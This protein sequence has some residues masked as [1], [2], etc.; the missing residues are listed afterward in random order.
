MLL[1]VII[2]HSKPQRP[3]LDPS[4]ASMGAST[5]HPDR[6]A[7]EERVEAAL[8]LVL[9]AHS[10]G[11]RRGERKDLAPTRRGV[12]GFSAR[13]GRR[14]GRSGEL[15]AC[16]GRPALSLHGDHR[17]KQPS[18]WLAVTASAFHESMWVG[19][20]GSIS[21]GERDRKRREKYCFFM[22]PS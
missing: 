17:C 10:H 3:L 1:L 12:K 15:R 2:A 16:F 5:T 22:D 20:R 9:V 4:T 18:T 14:E 6:C 11:R 21:F 19:E 7:T 8:P 13:E